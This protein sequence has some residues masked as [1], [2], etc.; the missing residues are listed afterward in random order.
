MGKEGGQEEYQYSHIISRRTWGDFTTCEL[1]RLKTC[2]YPGK[3]QAS[4]SHSAEKL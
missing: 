3:V 4:T 1:R 2:L